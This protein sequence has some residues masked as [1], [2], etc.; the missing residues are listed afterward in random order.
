VHATPSNCVEVAP[1]GIAT[2]WLD[3]ALPF[4]L[5]TNVP[6]ETAVQALAAE[7][8]TRL[9]PAPDGALTMDWIDHRVPFHAS[10]KGCVVPELST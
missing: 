10:A 4:H 9:S 7:Q 8:E 1:V 5:S 2:V 3:H 6:P